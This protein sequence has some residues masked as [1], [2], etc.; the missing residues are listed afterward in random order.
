LQLIIM[1][2][3]S[4]EITLFKPNWNSNNY[5]AKVNCLLLLIL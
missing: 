4:E 1:I 5:A 3:A 2:G